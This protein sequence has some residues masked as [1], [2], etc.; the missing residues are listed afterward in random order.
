MDF[1]LA[2]E[3]RHLG[4]FINI[5]YVED[6]E[7]V[8]EQVLKML[9]KLFNSVDV[10]KDGLEA[11]GMY[12]LNSYDLIITDIKMPNM[13][14]V[15]FSQ[16]VMEQNSEQA[17]LLISA[18]RN[19][20]DLLKLIELGV[21]GFILK[22]IDMKKFLTKLYTI[23]KKIYA[24]KMMKLHYA[25][26]KEA[27][28]T[29]GSF[30]EEELYNKDALTSLYNYKYFIETIRDSNHVE[31]AILL[32]IDDF[33]L[34]NDYYSFAHGNH[35]LFQVS[36]ILRQKALE[37]GYDLFRIA[38]DDFV[39]LKI[40]NTFGCNSMVEQTKDIISLLESQTFNIMGS[41][42][43]SISVSAGIAYSQ[44]RLIESLHQA[45]NY[46][47]KHKLK[48]A[49][50]KDIPDHTLDMKNILRVKKLLQ[51]SLDKDLLVPLYQQIQM[52]DK[53][54]KHEVLMRIKDPE[55][56]ANL[57]AP[58][59]FLDIARRYGY[60][61]E[62]SK[63]VITKALNEIEYKEGV[64][65]INIS[66]AD[67][68]NEDFLFM[69]EESIVSKNIGNR[70]IFEIV[71]SE[72]LDNMES[73]RY[74]IDRFR[75]LGVKIAI[76]DFGSGY[77][78]FAHIFSLMPDFIKID[79]SL[80]KELVINNN[81]ND[82][83]YILIQTVIEF[84]HKLDIE[85]IAEFISSKELYDILMQLGVDGVQGYYIAKPKYLE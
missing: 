1:E 2:R 46:A 85:V 51:E 70:L 60:Y 42:N 82:N 65:S 72:S 22:P 69:L 10:A 63:K 79:G 48:Y 32:H 31:Y 39:F 3:I 53:Q 58:A 55:D 17:I 59:M 26:M 27:L 75:K 8:K 20:D 7:N 5:L 54:I 37:Y 16:R 78:N 18:Y 40:D 67:I 57:I 24:S 28:S 23:S 50:F 21:T 33:K 80:V 45:L 49:T 52:R 14:G 43:I 68:I 13:N 73:V 66:F 34:I 47:I 83:V 6:D 71:E 35:L 64:F 56:E 44:Y 9:L 62:I 36:N 77:S 29:R 25:D 15:E 19:S 41:N 30:L 74:F 76:D 12:E 61:N 84:A 11:L 81:I 4:S 38:D